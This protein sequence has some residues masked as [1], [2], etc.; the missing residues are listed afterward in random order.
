LRLAEGTLN[1]ETRASM[2]TVAEEWVRFAEESERNGRS[3][4]AGYRA[5]AWQCM[6]RAH[7]VNDPERRAD[8]LGFAGVWLSLTEPTKDELRGAYE[9][10]PQRAG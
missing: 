10:P 2:L 8:L 3:A 1:P 5:K 6:S 7:T 4:S 9:L